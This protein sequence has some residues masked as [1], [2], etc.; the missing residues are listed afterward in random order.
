VDG[1]VLTVDLLADQ[2]ALGVTSKAPKWRVAYKYAPDQAE[3]KLLKV[4]WQVGKTGK[5][6]PRATMEPVDLAGTTVQHATLHNLD[7]IL[8]KDIRVGD[9]VVVEK[10]GEIIPQVVESK[11]EHR[12]GD[13]VEISAPVTCPSCGGPIERE[14]GE[15][16]HRCINP[17]CPAQFR[18]KLIWFAGRN[19]MDIDGLGEKLID[20]I[21][22]QGLVTH[23]A[24]LF[25]L[26]AEP[27]AGLERMGEKSAQNAVEG[28]A[29]AKSRG[30]AR[31]LA[32][33]GIR[34]IGNSTS[35]TL[36]LHYK[37]ID[38]LLAADEAALTAV[39][40]VGP[41]VAASL[42]AYLH[43]EVGAGTLNALREAGVDLTSHE[44][45][46]APAL[47]D[48]PFAGKK[49]VL[50]GGLEHFTRPKLKER[51]EAMGAKVSS[52]V[53]KNTDLVIAG[54]DPGSK[55]TKAQ[56][57]GVEIW[58]EAALLEHVEPE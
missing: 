57:L 9:T 39:P 44:Y 50:T 29:A 35:R 49:I 48:S 52:S 34:Q 15:A 36:A 25:A 2:E 40:D 54:E 23:F 21:L 43:S 53:S 30:M 55:F 56:D 12:A 22:E 11:T 47:G 6:T 58:D 4:E 19:Q 10:A 20:Q 41:I 1:V 27:L 32:S 18:G 37:D 28:I 45:G 46:Q 51:L 3:T 5:L 24:D 13:A 16:A 31:V 42:Y 8:R 7:E 14:E 38:A 26:K 17:E 33:L